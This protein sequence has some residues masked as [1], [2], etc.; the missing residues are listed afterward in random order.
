MSS[1]SYV[2]V[3]PR[4]CEMRG[5]IEVAD[6]SEALRRIKEMGLFP[7]KLLDTTERKPA[8]L[9]AR[10]RAR[11]KL[12]GRTISVPF[13]SA[14]VKP[15]V[16]TVF[17]RQLATLVEAGLPLLRGLR[18]L[19]E[20]EGNPTMRNVIGRLSADIEGGGSLGE[21]VAAQ[22]GVFNPLY[23]NMVRAGEISGAL[24]VTLGRLAQFMEKAQKIK[25]KVKAALFYPCAVLVV[26][27]GILAVLMVYVVPR[28]R[29]VFDGL[30][31]GRDMPA[32]SLFIFGLS[33]A[34]RHHAPSVL[35]GIIAVA[36]A[37]CFALR[38]KLG[39]RFFDQFKLTMPILGTVFRKAAIARFAR[40]LGTLASNGVPILQALNIVKETAGNV[41]VGRVVSSV[42]ENVEQG[43]PMAP[44]LKASGVFPALVAGMVDVGEQT[45]ALP[46]ML[47]KVADNYDDEVDD[48]TNALTSLLEPIMIVVL[49]VVVGSIVIAMFWPIVILI[50]GGMGGDRGD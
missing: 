23:V 9:P 5:N 39:R 41:I 14:R 4:G 3:D 33:D 1:Y 38:T 7:T 18:L 34:A 24:E 19:E 25:G 20:Q 37:F 13:V 47:M 21:A 30:M 43:E 42:H 22:P 2:A 36:V 26:A 29:Q 50:N 49:A 40:T 44:T 46:E 28:F 27:A 11:A 16:L 15:K 8:N 48:A 12:S 31:Q 45:G 17:T 10:P 35:A 6:Q 32:F